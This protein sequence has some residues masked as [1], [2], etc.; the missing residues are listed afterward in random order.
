MLCP[1]QLKLTSGFFV[2]RPH[3]WLMFKLV[4]TRSPRSFFAQ[5][6]SS[7][8]SHRIYWCMGCFLTKCRTLH[9]TFLDWFCSCQAISLAC[10][11]LPKYRCNVCF[12]SAFWIST[13][14]SGAIENHQYCKKM[15]IQH[16]QTVAL[17]H[18]VRKN[19]KILSCNFHSKN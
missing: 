10:L 19:E 11:S 13:S 2:A 6:L 4:S 9:L 15:F 7:W 16:F 12:I 5:L 17:N 14:V 8:V 18:K 3:W 1:R